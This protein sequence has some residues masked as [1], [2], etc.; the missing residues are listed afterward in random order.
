MADPE[1][2]IS[3]DIAE[4]ETRPSA[5]V[6]TRGFLFADLRGY[7]S[8]VESRGAT[9][10]AELLYRYRAL[11]RDA[12]ARHRGAEIKTEGDS[13][14]VVFTSVS[15]AVQCGLDIAAA[16]RQAT[17]EHPDQPIEVGIGVHAGETVE[18]PEGYVGSAVNM[19]ARLCSAAGPGEVLVSETV[20]ALTANTSEIVYQPAG[21]RKLKGI[22]E[23]TPVYVALP[24]GSV[25]R[26]A[27]RRAGRVAVAA[28]MAALA[29]V[30][31]AVVWIA[32]PFDQQAGAEGSPATGG[33]PE[34][35]GPIAIVVPTLAPEQETPE[36][37][38]LQLTPGHYRFSQ[39]RPQTSFVVDNEQWRVT[40]DE[41]DGFELVRWTGPDR[42][43]G[44]IAAAF[45]QV[46]FEE[47][48]IDGETRLLEGTPAALIEWLQ[49][50]PNVSATSPRPFNIG[51]YPGLTTDITLATETSCAEEISGR[52]GAAFLFAVG[53]TS[54]WLGAE[55]SVR[56]IVVDVA[57]QPITLLVGSLEP[58]KFD[59]VVEAADAILAT[60]EFAP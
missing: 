7:T 33:E 15:R 41:P 3:P 57:A 1:P 52:E 4:T 48:C 14:Y 51:G 45:V 6:L 35:S 24:A 18:T 21:R 10:A 16:A 50:H 31:V 54:F 40:T 36:D 9:T 27:R 58:E 11:V 25:S 55:E 2:A 29:M 12:V 37:W 39:F 28:A 13:F 43:D 44:Y 56:V 20:R 5:D 38:P 60:M 34:T 23:P 32:R 53:E 17:E 47:P 42:A 46:V 30:I 8:F 49:A 22:V 19:A 26:A 59:G